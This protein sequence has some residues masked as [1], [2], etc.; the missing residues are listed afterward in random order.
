M[1]AGLE[2]TKLELT[3]SKPIVPA[4]ARLDPTRCPRVAKAVAHDTSGSARLQTVALID[5]RYLLSGYSICFAAASLFLRELPCVAA[6]VCA[7]TPMPL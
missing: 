2:A 6:F 4:S 7:F 3:N 5:R 1:P